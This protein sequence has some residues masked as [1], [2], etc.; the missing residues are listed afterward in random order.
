MNNRLS[1]RD[2]IVAVII[3]ASLLFLFWQLARVDA[4]PV[5]QR[6]GYCYG[7]KYAATVTQ[8]APSGLRGVW[9]VTVDAPEVGGEYELPTTRWF[10]IGKS[11]TL[12]GYTC[13]DY[14]W[15]SRV[16]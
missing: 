14:F 8:I 5:E 9:W 2:R 13:G 10:R 3:V 11:V 12:Q 1:W 15:P 16:S 4:A 6:A 7:G